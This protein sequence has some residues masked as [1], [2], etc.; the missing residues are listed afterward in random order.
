MKLFQA[1]ALTLVI[2]LLSTTTSAQSIDEPRF[3]NQLLGDFHTPVIVPGNSGTFSLSINNPDPF[4]MTSNMENVRL[5]VSIYQYGTLEESRMIPDISLP[6]FIV[7][8]GS[9]DYM[10]S[11][12]TIIPGGQHD[13]SFTISTQRSTPHGSSFSQSTYFVRFWLEFEYEG[14]NYTMVSRGYFTDEQWYQLTETESGTGNV[15]QTYLGELGF[16]GLIPDSSFAVKQPIPFWPFYLLICVTI[17]IGILAVCFYILDNPGMCPRLER[18]LLRINGRLIQ[19]RR[20]LF[21]RNK[22]Q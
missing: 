8:A 12:L 14:Q 10:L 1:I 11:N 9:T 17:F 21:R 6:P 5:N 20:N 4:N 13:V 7:E 15:N 2:F 3:V 18:R 16:D 19:L 22:G